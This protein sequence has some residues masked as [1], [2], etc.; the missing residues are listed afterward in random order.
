MKFLLGLLL[1]VCGSVYATPHYDGNT[2]P[3]L[4]TKHFLEQ[5]SSIAIY[6]ATTNSFAYGVCLGYIRGLVEGHQITVE[7]HARSNK[8]TVV[9][10]QRLWC[11]PGTTTND[12]VM[13]VVLM[14]VE[15]NPVE[16]N[17]LMEQFVGINAATTIIIKSVMQGFKC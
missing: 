7:L 8:G 5:C 13:R 9:A 10:G 16:F 6:D 3:P 12:K 2:V 17:V 1:F 11:V 14:W 4:R 15:N